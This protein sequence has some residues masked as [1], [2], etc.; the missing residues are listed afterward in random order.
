MKTVIFYIIVICTLLYLAK[1]QIE[2]NP[3]K[4]T[5]NDWHTPVATILF[6]IGLTLMRTKS[7]NDGVNATIEAIIELIDEKKA[8]NNGDVVEKKY[9]TFCDTDRIY[10][11]YPIE[12]NQLQHPEKL[13][14]YIR[15]GVIRVVELK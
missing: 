15:E 2:F 7:Y 6:I 10:G 5:L 3:F 4:I 1:I 12:I 8:T 14:E 11:W 9:E 13:D